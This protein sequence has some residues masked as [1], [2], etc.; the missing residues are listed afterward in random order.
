MA[1]LTALPPRMVQRSRK[2][3]VEKVPGTPAGA[4]LKKSSKLRP[5]WQLPGS[6]VFPALA[7]KC[8]ATSEDGVF[9][10][11]KCWGST[12][13]KTVH[14]RAETAWALW[15]WS[16]ARERSVRRCGLHLSS[17]MSGEIFLLI[18]V[19]HRP[20]KAALCLLDVT[21]WW[22]KKWREILVI[23]RLWIR[24]DREIPVQ[25][26]G[27]WRSKIF[28]THASS[29]NSRLPGEQE[30]SSKLASKSDRR[31]FQNQRQWV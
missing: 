18:S 9:E 29:P 10:K 30:T 11:P 7:W 13:A 26:I 31:S 27:F 21:W 14:G 8:V 15:W 3:V 2:W 25:K 1:W 17:D 6:T 23:S 20:K 4:G 22:L 5:L 16:R 24:V 19:S 28:L 12:A